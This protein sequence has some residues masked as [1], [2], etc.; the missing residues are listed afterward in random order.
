VKCAP[1]VTAAAI[2]FPPHRYSQEEV[3][4]ALA[5][6]AGQ[7]FLRFAATAGVG[8][9]QLA[10]PLERYR[11]LTGFTEANNAFADVAMDL[12]ERAVLAALDKAG[13]RPCE[14]DVVSP[15]P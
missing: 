3:V 5:D 11:T 10:L 8:A 15:P 7:D 9:R 12:G 4:S 6:F 14:V 2:E 1:A 13:L